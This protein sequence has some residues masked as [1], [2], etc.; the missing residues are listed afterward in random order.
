MF[1]LSLSLVLMLL[2]AVIGHRNG[3]PNQSPILPSTDAISPQKAQLHEVAD[4][5][6]DIYQTLVDMRYLDP[7]VSN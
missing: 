6:L 1:V 7:V 4:L 3:M 5:M 2:S